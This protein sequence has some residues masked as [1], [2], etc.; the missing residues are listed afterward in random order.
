MGKTLSLLEIHEHTLG[1]K[2]VAMV[3]NIAAGLTDIQHTVK[4]MW[5]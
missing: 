5:T 2:L 3:F 4:R 1:R